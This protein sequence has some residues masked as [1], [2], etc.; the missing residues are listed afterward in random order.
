MTGLVTLLFLPASFTMGISWSVITLSV[1]PSLIIAILLVVFLPETKNR[2]YDEIRLQ[3][4]DYIFSGLA[5]NDVKCNNMPQILEPEKDST[6]RAIPKYQR[7]MSASSYASYGSMRSLHN[8]SLYTYN[9]D[10]N[11]SFDN[12]FFQR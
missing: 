3:I 1:I 9:N 10:I 4:G 5:D 8:N 12:N 6:S 2:S 7:L 11:K